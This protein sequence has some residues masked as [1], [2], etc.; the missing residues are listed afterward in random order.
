MYKLMIVDDEASTRNGLRD[1]VD[2]TRFGMTV[3]AVAEHGEAALR[4][5]GLHK[6]EIVLTDV[7]MPVMDGIRLSRE[8]RRIDPRV[9][10]VFISGHND[11]EYVKSALQVSAVDYILKPIN[12][13][14]LDRVMERVAAL[15]REDVQQQD[16]LL[17]MNAKLLQSMPLLKERFFAALVNDGGSEASL[18]EKLELLDIPFPIQGR[19]LTA[20]VSLDDGSDTMSG[21]REREKQLLSFAV[22]NICQELIERFLN[23]TVFEHRQGE[24][25]CILKLT[26]ESADDGVYNLFLEIKQ[27]LLSLLKISVTIGVGQPV[28]RLGDL[29][30]SYRTA[31]LAAGYKLFLGKNRIITI[32]TLESSGGSS[33]W[34][35]GSMLE[36]GSS[37]L[38]AGDSAKMESF[39]RQLFSQLAASRNASLRYC[40]NVCMQLALLGSGLLDELEMHNEEWLR[41]DLE[42]SERIS[43]LE[44]MEDLENALNAYFAALC[45]AVRSKRD[46]RLSYLVDRIRQYVAA[47]YAQEINIED[48]AKHVYL[49]S[50]Y[51]CLLFK[52]ETGETINDYVTKVRM[53][54][55]KAMLA[56]LKYK[57]YD[58]SRAVGY[59]DSSYFSKVF[60]RYTGLTPTEYRGKCL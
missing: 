3:C 49:T 57:L 16:L 22:M 33:F 45:E 37:I 23:G 4:Q 58:I 26:G 47:N 6:P 40:R 29:P 44:T 12:F 27:Q 39:V 20:V 28:D 34:I 18:T 51:V 25:V 31:S 52:Q 11:I 17:R 30:D 42:L 60:K 36:K 7:K 38:K 53:E 50:T 10:L 35:T 21:M 46:S 13:A 56:D 1:Y 24:F 15:I 32:D 5:A 2:W 8:L 48:I 41:R 9:K 59:N 19:Y 14:E 43:R 55:A 54:Q